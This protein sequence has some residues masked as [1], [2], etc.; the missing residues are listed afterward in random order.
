MSIIE[1]IRFAIASMW[2]AMVDRIKAWGGGGPPP[3]LPK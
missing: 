2:R 3:T 1:Q